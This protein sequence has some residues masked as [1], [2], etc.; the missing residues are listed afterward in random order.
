MAEERLD[1]LGYAAGMP[2]GGDA[3]GSARDTVVDGMPVAFQAMAA[4]GMCVLDYIERI[5]SVN[6]PERILA[7]LQTNLRNFGVDYFCFGRP[8]QYAEQFTFAASKAFMHPGWLSHYFENRYM[9]INPAVPEA[10][11]RREPVYWSDIVDRPELGRK[12][13]K[14]FQDAS[15][16]GLDNGLF[17]PIFGPRNL[18]AKMIC[19]GKEIDTSPV[20]RAGI[21]SMAISTFNRLIRPRELETGYRKLTGREIECLRWVAQGKSDWDISAI[22]NISE[23]TV[24]WHIESAKRRLGV[25]TRIQAVVGA[26]HRGEI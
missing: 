13:K 5:Q 2:A 26:L 25:A 9:D 18:S 19:L 3:E 7:L 15:E 6:E 1:D 21:H 8:S 23:S 20:V 16:F 4:N 17:V 11:H 12:Q 10:L 24:H 14:L 22:L